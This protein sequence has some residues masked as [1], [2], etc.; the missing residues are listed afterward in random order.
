VER[1]KQGCSPG[2]LPYR[3]VAAE[4]TPSRRDLLLFCQLLDHGELSEPLQTINVQVSS[5]GWGR[6]VWQ[7]RAAL[8]AGL[9]ALPPRPVPNPAPS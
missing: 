5:R 4:L 1:Y 2:L 9:Q 7:G 3:L 6:A 8:G